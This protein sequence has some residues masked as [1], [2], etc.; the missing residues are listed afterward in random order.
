MSLLLD[1]AITWN[2]LLDT[3]Y[4]ITIGHK[5]H[6]QTLHISFHPIDFYHLSGIHYATDVDF[7]LHKRE[8]QR[9]K[10]LPALLSKKLDDTLIEKSVHWSKISDRLS[11][12]SNLSR[13]LASHFSI[14]Q[15]NQKKLP[16]H[17][18]ISAAYLIYCDETQEGIFLFLDKEET[19]F[20]CKSIFSKDSRDYRTNQTKWTILKK[21]KNESG[22][23]STI[24]LNPAYKENEAP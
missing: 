15:F 10:L 8:Y 13:I 19:A 6:A 1:T 21:E 17:S 4:D 7:G 12:I 18:T 20:Y 16:F 14:Y 22:T 11:A 2:N 9:K 24:Y 5:Q 23:K 3:S